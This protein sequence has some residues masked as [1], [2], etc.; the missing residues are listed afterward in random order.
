M[1]MNKKI[2]LI[3]PG[4]IATDPRLVKEAIALSK[5]GYEVHIIF[6]QYMQYLL[7]EDFKILNNYPWTY[8]CINWSNQTL[9][10]RVNKYI[11]GIIQK[12]A[13]QFPKLYLSSE[14]ILNR[15]FFWQ[16][17]K[18]IQCKADIYI[19]HNLGA[20]PIAY[21]AAKK[22]KKSV[23]F[24][25]EDFHRY[26]TTD[27]KNSRDYLVKVLIEDKYLPTV[28][29]ITSAS[30]LIALE[31]EKL[32]DKKV[33]PILNV[34][35]KVE[36]HNE[37]ENNNSLHLFW[38]SQ[39][40]GK[41]RGLEMVIE[42][43]GMVSDLELKFHL[44]GEISVQDKDYFNNLFIK[45]QFPIEKVCYHPTISADEVIQLA[46]KFDIGLAT[47][48]GVPFN[49][50]ICLTNKIFTYI[51]AGNAVVYS[52]T[53]GQEKLMNQYKEL[54]FMYI[55]GDKDSLSNIISYYYYNREVLRQHKRNAY[56]LGQKELNWEK[57]QVKFIEF[58]NTIKF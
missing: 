58:I 17:K 7:A 27:N 21:K 50:N 45:S 49:R 52:N 32:Y 42:S 20:L 24:D 6:S 11:S 36:I 19:A 9:F 12:I 40:I 53:L 18:A 48:I 25:A 39:T 35:P 43:L 30:Q 2:C 1:E 34:F 38:F 22:N 15:L 29:Y 4:H 16:L 44:L 28:Y 57:E 46:S 31:Y 55:N 3:T 56:Q 10:S 13:I 54:G 47:E 14:L 5:N 37:N 51:Q 33:Q 8:D 41:G 23:G 26:E